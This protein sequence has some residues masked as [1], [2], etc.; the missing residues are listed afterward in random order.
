MVSTDKLKASSK[1]TTDAPSSQKF[2]TS[3]NSHRPRTITEILAHFPL[4]TSGQLPRELLEK[5]FEQKGSFGVLL[6][7]NGA[8]S[9]RSHTPS[10]SSRA[11]SQAEE[12]SLD[13][14]IALIAALNA[15]RVEDR[16]TVLLVNTTREA[17][18]A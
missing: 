15:S 10:F 7:A 1:I 6:R 9:T 5:L 14:Q 2:V 11:T 17:K 16:T 18:R 8:F 13:M 3:F 4:L 12:L